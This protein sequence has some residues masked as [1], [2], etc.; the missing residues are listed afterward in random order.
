MTL[1]HGM[2]VG[3]WTGWVR[4]CRDGKRRTRHRKI[5][6]ASYWTSSAAGLA[7][8]DALGRRDDAHCISS[9]CPSGLGQIKNRAIN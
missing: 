6:P 3:V 8:M 5:G 2:F 9:A 1:D 4:T 7:A